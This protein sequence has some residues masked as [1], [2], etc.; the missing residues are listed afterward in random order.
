MT[1][2]VVMVRHSKQASHDSSHKKKAVAVSKDDGDKS[3][4]DRRNRQ[5]RLLPTENHPS[6]FVSQS[7]TLTILT[8]P[9]GFSDPLE[10]R[11]TRFQL[12]PFT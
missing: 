6:R 7:A 8:N 5:H 11:E 4:E 12:L 2:M 10:A 9:F 3:V 1:M